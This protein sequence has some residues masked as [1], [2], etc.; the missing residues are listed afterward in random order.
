MPA[1]IT[2][3]SVRADTPDGRVLFDNL[4]LAIGAERIGLVGRNG[5]GKST[6][7]SLIAGTSAP[8]SGTVSRAGVV[9]VLPQL[10]AP[11]PGA[12][13]ADL[14]GVG[15]AWDRLCRIE[16]EE[17]TPET[18][19]EDLIEADWTLPGRVAAAL[20]EVGLSR[21]DASAP[22]ASLSG[23]QM[24]RAAL[25]GLLIAA[26]DVILLDEPTNN[27]DAAGRSLLA[28]V[29]RRWKG[30]A[31]VVSHDRALLRG[32][33][34][35]VEL[36]SLG[37]TSYGGG[38]DLYAERKAQA[39][40]AAEH[41]LEAAERQVRQAAR[42][43]QIGRERKAR[44]DAAGRR[45]AAKGSEPKILLGAQAERA[46]N[47]GAREGRLADRAAQDAALAREAADARVERLRRLAFDLPSCGLPAG[48][49]VLD[50]DAVGFSYPGGPP[51]LTDLSFRLA[52][53]ER[54]ALVGGNGAGKS[55]LIRLAT[56]GLEPSTGTVTRGVR[57]AL[58]DQRA[59]VLDETRTILENFRRLNP[60]VGAN[61]AHAALARFL[62]RNVAAHQA[63][64]ALSGGERLR[65]ALA[66]VLMAADPPQLLILDEPTN[67]LDLDS[68]EAVEDA[69]ADYDGAL[70][71]AS[72]DE[73]FLDA[74][75]VERRITLRPG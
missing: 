52:G 26:P 41:D 22:A 33:D 6:L 5:V 30:G 14:L 67:H 72:H 21:R 54:M 48:R 40:A 60:A 71:I 46:E 4:N 44:R 49:V 17:G 19:E 61:E 25:A 50:F 55:T 57:A 24:T 11:P 36:S 35:I 23:G 9:G 7:L 69:L 56:G 42:E 16:A 10:H 43:A 31:V 39:V 37:A 34:R 8:V 59:A 66:C 70:L 58:L 74:V 2:L 47:S 73:D 51:V 27:L 53:P 13:L 68:V 1:F 75:G 62:F 15:P 38:Y 18:L 28:D 20:G 12:R 65:A 63:V 3:D 64:G 29:L 32:V 45:F